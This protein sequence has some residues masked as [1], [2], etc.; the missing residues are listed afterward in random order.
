MKKKTLLVMLI[1]F[2]TLLILIPSGNLESLRLKGF[3]SV[4]GPDWDCIC[5]RSASDCG[6]IIDL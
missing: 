6:C 2:F 5:P 3:M 4:S 1:I